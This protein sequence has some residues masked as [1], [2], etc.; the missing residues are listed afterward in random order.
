M[1]ANSSM[2]SDSPRALGADPRRVRIASRGR[3][4]AGPSGQRGAERLASLRERRVDHRERGRAD[5]RPPARRRQVNETRPE[6]TLGTGQKTFG[7]TLPALRALAYQAS[8][9]LGMP[10]TLEPGRGDQPVGDLLLHHHQAVRRLGSWA[11]RCSTTG[12]A[13][14]YGR[15]ATSAVGAPYANSSAPTL[16]RVPVQHGQLGRVR[17]GALRHGA[18]SAAASTGSISTA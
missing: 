15:F 7:G 10:Y 14:L 13:T 3:R 12:T 6:S 5:R 8:L 17:R 9:T 18:G 11:S 2:V 4:A 16:Q 1:A